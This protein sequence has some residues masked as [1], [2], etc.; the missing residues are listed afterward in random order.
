MTQH[1]TLTAER[2]RRFS[3]D[4]QILM[5]A[6]EMNRGAKLYAD[7]VRRRASYER[8]LALTDL[9]IAVA[10]RASVRRELLRWRDLA[11]A[12]YLEPRPDA[13]GHRAALRC[14]LLFTPESSRQIPLL[15]ALRSGA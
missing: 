9:T 12:L 2:W 13:D 7:D 1:A 4:Q 11:A 10:S 14:L 15:Q 5:I 6:N 8:V 3:L